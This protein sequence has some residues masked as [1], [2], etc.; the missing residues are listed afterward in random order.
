[1]EIEAKI[2]YSKLKKIAQA[3]S[4]QYTVKVG[5]LAGKGGNEP[6]SE[7]L[8]MAGLGAVHEFGAR[9]KVTDKMRG[10]FYY[11][12]G[13]HLKKSTTEII[14]PARSWLQMPLQQ[15]NAIINK[16]K[17]R[18]KTQ[19]ELIEYVSKTGDFMS[20]AIMLGSAAVEQ[21]QEAFATGGFGKWEPDSPL[22]I[23]DK[24]SSM[25]LVGKGRGNESSGSLRRAVTYEVEENG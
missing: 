2:D 21:I 13:V 25:P 17:K 5:L 1:M 18:F 16:L 23:D 22:T 15:K 9:I 11:H 8:D 19:D 4:K 12:F 24:G 3:M 7:N 6:V 10:F 20:L 14:I